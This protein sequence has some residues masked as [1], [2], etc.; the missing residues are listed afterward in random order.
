MTKCLILFSVTNL[1]AEYFEMFSISI[2]CEISTI[3]G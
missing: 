3:S 2:S 1:Y